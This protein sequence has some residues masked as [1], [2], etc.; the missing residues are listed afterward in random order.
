MRYWGF[1]VNKDLERVKSEVEEVVQIRRSALDRCHRIKELTTL[2][3][4]RKDGK[5]LLLYR[6]KKEH[7]LNQ[8]KYI[9]I[10]GHVEAGET[11][12]EASKRE[13]FE[14]TGLTVRKQR[15]IAK[16][17][18]VNENCVERMYLFRVD[19]VDGELSRD[20]DEGELVF[21]ESSRMGEVPM[22]EGDRIFLPLLDEESPSPYSMTL[23]YRGSCLLDC[24]GP[25][26]ELKVNSKKTHNAKKFK[27]S[28]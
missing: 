22:W 19:A 15:Y 28:T 24:I 3:Y 17:D 13:F 2:S 23:I 8:G 9:G 26:K 4:Y 18:F 16:I 5:Y 10:G 20:C 14:E 11:Y 6:D 1:E 7:D 21:V 25:Y 27:K 12:L